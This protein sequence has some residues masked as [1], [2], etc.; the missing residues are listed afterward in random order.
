MRRVLARTLTQAG[1]LVDTTPDGHGA[2]E[3][4][5]HDPYDAVLSDISMPDMDGIELLRAI[6]QNQFDVPV[7]LSTG[8]PSMQT[9]VEA[10]KYGALQYLVKPVARHELLQA[11]ERAVQTAAARRVHGTAPPHADAAGAALDRRA[12]EAAF[13]RALNSLW[14]A[15]QPIV[16]ASSGRQCAQEFL[17]RTD[18][19]GLDVPETL[20]LAAERLGRVYELGARVRVAIAET[21]SAQTLRGDLYVNL[22]PLE[23]ADEALVDLGDPLA[24]FTDRVVFEVTEHANFSDVAEVV[25]RVSMLRDR[26]FRLAIDD[27]GA[28]YAGLNRFTALQPDIVKLDMAL[29]RGIGADPVK[30]KLVQSMTRVAQ[31]LHVVVVAEGIETTADLV[32]VKSAGCDLLQGYLIGRPAPSGSR[33]PNE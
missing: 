28:G 18:E 17:L 4:L 27:L 2:L 5:R 30:Q 7:V 33:E 31:E 6:R 12:A 20:L 14:M 24:P 25:E 29:V 23:L 3:A 11:I 19:R 22:H 9:A 26:G 15:T 8:L 13:S 21:I 32:A 16:A 1:Y 10:V